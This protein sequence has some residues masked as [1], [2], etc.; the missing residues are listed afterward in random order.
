MV[1]MRTQ[2]LFWFCLGA[3][4]QK[5]GPFYYFYFWANL[6]PYSLTKLSFSLIRA[7]K[8]TIKSQISSYEIRYLKW[9]S[10]FKVTLYQHTLSSELISTATS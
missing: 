6:N 2:L 7:N 3:F 9:E 4:V 8:H 10:K 5:F 1:G